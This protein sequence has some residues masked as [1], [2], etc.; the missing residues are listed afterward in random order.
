[1]LND[2]IQ[3]TLND[4]LHLGPSPSQSAS[5]RRSLARRNRQ[6]RGQQ[7]DRHGDAARRT[8]WPSRSPARQQA[9]H[10]RA[11]RRQ[12]DDQAQHDERIVGQEHG[13]DMDSD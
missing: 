3:S 10:Q 8:A 1:M 5:T 12:E 11:G 9:D 6:P 2:G 4:V 7:E 13:S